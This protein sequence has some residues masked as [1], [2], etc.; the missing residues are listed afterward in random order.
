[1]RHTHSIK[2]I[3][4]AGA[5][6]KTHSLGAHIPAWWQ[7]AHAICCVSLFVL[8]LRHKIRVLGKI[9]GERWREEG[10]GVTTPQGSRDCGVIKRSES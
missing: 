5:R 2:H 3:S 7:S 6:I 9:R 4:R 1:M 10:R 8:L